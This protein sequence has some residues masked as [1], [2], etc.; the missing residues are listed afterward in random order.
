MRMSITAIPLIPAHI[1]IIGPMGNVC[2]REVPVDQFFQTVKELYETF[3]ITDIELY[4]PFSYIDEQA[5]GIEKV[6]PY[7]DKY[8][9]WVC[10]DTRDRQKRRIQEEAMK[11]MQK[12][13]GNP[14]QIITY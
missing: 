7:D 14:G 5:H 11:T 13:L 9:I 12:N 6:L 8:N 2:H 3:D 10:G 1:V 4:G